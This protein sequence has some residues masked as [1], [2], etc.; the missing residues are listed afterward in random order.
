LLA[1]ALPEAVAAAVRRLQADPVFTDRLAIK[2]RQTV[3]ERF[4]IDIMVQNTLAVYRRVL[5]C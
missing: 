2:G 1:A 5:G 4:S 3:T